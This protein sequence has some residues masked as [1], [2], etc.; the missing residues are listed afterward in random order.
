[1]R[2]ANTVRSLTKKLADTVSATQA[3]RI[4]IAE[5]RA[6]IAELRQQVLEVTTCPL[7]ITDVSQ[8]IRDKVKSD[9][10]HWVSTYGGSLIHGEIALLSPTVTHADQVRLPDYGKALATWGAFCAAFPDQAIAQLEALVARVHDSSGLPHAER[11]AVL[12]RLTSELETLEAEEEAAI[13]EMNLAG[14]T[15]DHRPEV[16]E[17]RQRAAAATQSD[18]AKVAD[19]RARQATIDARHKTRTVNPDRRTSG[20]ES[21]YLKTGRVP[22]A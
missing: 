15:I 7:L 17:R 21:T 6:R 8:R 9:G 11:P 22:S 14:V 12:E 19:R 18:E 16:I 13:D 3:A 5:V 10:D 20:G 2:F 1:M 4:D